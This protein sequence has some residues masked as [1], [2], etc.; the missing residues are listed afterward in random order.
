MAEGEGDNKNLRLIFGEIK[1]G[2]VTIKTPERLEQFREG[3]PI[4]IMHLEDYV[5]I[6]DY[7]QNLKKD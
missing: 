7:I 3:D 4:I 1:D 2:N 5:W 6:L